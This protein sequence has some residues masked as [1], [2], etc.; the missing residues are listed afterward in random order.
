MCK[1]KCKCKCWQCRRTVLRV[2]LLSRSHASHGP[3]CATHSDAPATC[4]ADQNSIARL[5]RSRSKRTLACAALIADGSRWVT[6]AIARAPMGGPAKRVST[7]VTFVFWTGAAAPDAQAPDSHCADTR[8]RRR[9][10]PSGGGDGG[11]MTDGASL[12]SARQSARPR[13]NICVF[14]K[15]V[16]RRCVSV[17]K[18]RHTLETYGFVWVVR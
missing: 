2:A 18:W 7:G 15:E 11:R 13:R 14:L 5:L 1:C 10:A 12:V 17:E 8:R 6:S 4:A 16:G 3:H 9:A